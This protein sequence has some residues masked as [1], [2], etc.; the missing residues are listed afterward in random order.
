[1]DEVWRLAVAGVV[2]VPLGAAP[3]DVLSQQTLR[4]AL[5]LGV[6]ATALLHVLA[7][8]TARRTERRRADSVGCG[9]NTQRASSGV[10]S[11]PHP[12]AYAVILAGLA[13]GV[14]SGCVGLNGPPVALYLAWRQTAKDEARAMSAAAVW[15]LSTV[16]LFLFETSTRL[17]AGTARSAIALAP[18]LAIGWLAGSRLFQSIPL[19]RFQQLSVT[20][21]AAAGIVTM[22]VGRRR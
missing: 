9:D 13:A 10:Q 12:A 1:M 18:A 20:F 16:T 8:R 21:A 3:L 14:L 15:P 7:R 5:G 17:P 22:L 4:V 19:P 6:V 11:G 2:G